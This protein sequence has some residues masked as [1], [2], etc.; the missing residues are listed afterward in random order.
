MIF[1]ENRFLSSIT[2]TTCFSGSCAVTPRKRNGE[3][4]SPPPA[5]HELDEI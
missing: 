2:S 3:P 4:S 1:S 5:S